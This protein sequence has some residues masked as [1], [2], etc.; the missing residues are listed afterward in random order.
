MK[1][2]REREKEAEM[3]IDNADKAHVFHMHSV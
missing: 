3:K 1:R 2:K